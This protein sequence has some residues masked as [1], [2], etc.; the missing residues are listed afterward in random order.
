[1]YDVY[2]YQHFRRVLLPALLFIA[3]NISVYA[4][5]PRPKQTF[6]NDKLTMQMLPPYATNSSACPLPPTQ[7]H[8]PREALCCLRIEP[9]MATM[10][11]STTGVVLISPGRVFTINSRAQWKSL[12]IFVMSVIVKQRLVQTGRIDGPTEHLSQIL[13]AI[14]SS[15]CNDVCTGTR[16]VSI[17][18]GEWR[19]ESAGPKPGVR[20]RDSVGFGKRDPGA[21]L[22]RRVSGLRF[23]GFAR[24]S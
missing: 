13:A 23:R 1:M 4:P 8:S 7:M 10:Y 22:L 24:Q 3:T 12:H 18:S 6:I 19:V 14:R 9:S 17:G 2:S 16:R 11:T 15:F 21:A 20:K 5:P